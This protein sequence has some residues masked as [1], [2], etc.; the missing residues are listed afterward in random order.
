MSEDLPGRG[1]AATGR[2]GQEPLV[3]VALDRRKAA[4]PRAGVAC[5]LT[6]YKCHRRSKGSVSLAGSPAGVESQAG[7]CLVGL[8]PVLHPLLRTLR[9]FHLPGTV[10]YHRDGVM[11]QIHRCEQMNRLSRASRCESGEY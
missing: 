4:S 7:S 11:V 9:T 3:V 8:H 2:A 10:P 1:E 6:G 5:N